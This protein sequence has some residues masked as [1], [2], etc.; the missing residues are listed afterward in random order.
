[1]KYHNLSN[2]FAKILNNN[3][4][5]IKVAFKTNNN[6]MKKIHFRTKNFKKM[7][8]FFDNVGVFKL[9]CINCDKFYIGKTNRN[10]K[11]RYKEH[12]S[13]IKF[14]KTAPNSNFAIIDMF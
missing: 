10:F 8:P 7:S 1:M 13:E 12:I 4:N 3:V 11:T 5:N 6:L 9:K 2:N 14:K